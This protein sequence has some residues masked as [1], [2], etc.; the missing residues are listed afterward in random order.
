FRSA[1]SSPASSRLEMKLRCSSLLRKRS[2][3]SPQVAFVD[4]RRG[5]ENSFDDGVR[6]HAFRFALEVQKDPMPQRT[7]SHR[8]DV[9]ARNVQPIVQQCAD[10][11]AN[12]ESL[13]TAWARSI[14]DVLM[15]VRRESDP[16]RVILYRPRN[17]YSS[18]GD[19]HIEDF[20]FCQDAVDFGFVNARR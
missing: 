16:H 3:N 1:I 7:V 18:S 8:A 4:I 17:R 15:T 20:V 14:P 2:S 13:S 6:V 11:S 19:A 12:D 9:V 10:F 5:L